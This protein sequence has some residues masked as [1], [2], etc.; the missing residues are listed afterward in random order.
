MAKQ[1]KSGLCVG[2]GGGRRLRRQNRGQRP[3]GRRHVQRQLIRLT[4]SHDPLDKRLA[5][6]R[7]L[8]VADAVD[9]AKAAQGRRAAAGHVAERRVAEH[10][11]GRHVLRRRSFVPQSPQFVEQAPVDALP[12]ILGRRRLGRFGRPRRPQQP[13]RDFAP[14]QPPALRRDL[15]LVELAHFDQKLLAGQL[16]NPVANRAQVLVGQQAPGAE[17]VVTQLQDPL[18]FRAAEHLGRVIAAEPLLEPHHAG[19]DLLTDRPRVVDQVQLAETDIARVA[20]GRL[21]LLAEVLDDGAVPALHAA[22]E[23]Q[24]GGQ[25]FQGS[26]ARCRFGLF[27]DASPNA[28]VPA[29]EEQAALGFQAVAPGAAAFLLVVF[30]RL[31]HARVDHVADVRLVDA[32]AEGDRGHDRVGFVFDERVLV[33]ATVVVAQAGVVGQ[34]TIAQLLQ[35][36][37]GLVHVFARDAVD[38][39]RFAPVPLQHFADLPQ[40]VVPPLH[41]VDQ[42]GPIERADQDFRIAQLQLFRDIPPH[43][44]RCGGGI[45]V[46]A[47]VGESLLQHAQPAVLRAE[48][49][50][51]RADAMRLVDRHQRN[52]GGLE[53]LQC[54]LRQQPFGA[55]YSSRSRPPRTSSATRRRS[56]ADSVLLVHA[57]GTPQLRSEST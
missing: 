39:A 24:H 4:V 46:D 42:V 38:D 31:G 9:L 37:G 1:R 21:E 30:Q 22:A 56:E 20:R 51:P 19:E 54:P 55:K 23:I 14:Q 3:S 11:V 13:R 15:Q 40:A 45:G 44:V 10:D 17:P 25:G 7:Q 43:G 16:F 36:G 12:R 50:S 52:L 49:V 18:I 27:D 33:A 28:V 53:K 35:G 2:A 57:A 26:L 34:R 32:H 29:G 48:I 47:D 8:L 5:V 41:F 6:V